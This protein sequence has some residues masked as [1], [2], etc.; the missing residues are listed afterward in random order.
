ML[1]TPHLKPTRRQLC[2][3]AFL[4]LATLVW[5]VLPNS[6]RLKF[7][8]I[9]QAATFTVTTT[10]DD[11]PGSLR[12]AI[13]VSNLNMGPSANVINFNIPGVGVKTISPLSPLPTI[14]A[15]VTIDGFTQPGSGSS[16]LLIELDGTNAGANANGLTI[17]SGHCNIYSLVVNRFNAAGVSIQ[18]GVGNL[19]AG[20]RIGTVPAGNTDRGHARAGI[21]IGSNNNTIRANLISGNDGPGVSL[22]RSR[23]NS[24]T[25]NIIGTNAGATTALANRIGI[26][27]DQ[28]SLDNIIGPAVNVTSDMNIIAGNVFDGIGIRG[29]NNLIR[30]NM[31]GNNGIDAIPNGN[32]GILIFSGAANTIGG[33]SYFTTNVIS[34]N[35]ANGIEITSTAAVGNQIIGNRI[36]L[37]A[38]TSLEPLPNGA[39]GILI[40]IAASNNTIGGINTGSSLPANFIAYN[41]ANGVRVNRGFDNKVVGNYIHDNVGAGVFVGDPESPAG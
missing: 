28:E 19:I 18:T 12:Q 23:A 24:L 20:N 16:G 4:V 37:N 11:G 32:D 5:T 21:D 8:P 10:A 25:G 3:T 7:E 15:P 2:W 36:G 27:I 33:I 9:A 34:G 14:T 41:K 17:T 38:S 26:T 31:I 22:V 40:D 13:I 35:G 39:N 30:S 29:N 1:M 6:L